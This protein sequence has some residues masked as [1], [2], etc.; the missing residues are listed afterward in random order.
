MNGSSLDQAMAAAKGMK[1]YAMSGGGNDS[2]H[3]D[4]T[5]FD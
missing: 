5:P 2:Y 4:N 3:P 1:A